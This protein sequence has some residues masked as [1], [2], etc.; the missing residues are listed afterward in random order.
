[1]VIPEVIMR[2][3]INTALIRKELKDRGWSQA[4]LARRT[5][6]SAQNITRILVEKTALLETLDKLAKA[7]GYKKGKDLLL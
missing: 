3:R 7:L 6:L 2:T 4:E 5:G 1:M